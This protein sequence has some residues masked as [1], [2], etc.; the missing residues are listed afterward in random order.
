MPFLPKFLKVFR[1]LFTKSFL[2]GVW[3]KA[4]N[5]FFD[6]LKRSSC[7]CSVFKSEVIV[8]KKVQKLLPTIGRP[9]GQIFDVLGVAVKVTRYLA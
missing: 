8:A 6:K 5:S 2:N 3:G 1:K 9:F 7:G 4:P